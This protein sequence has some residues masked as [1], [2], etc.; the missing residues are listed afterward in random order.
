MNYKERKLK[1][2]L[3]EQTLK[4][5][6]EHAGKNN[7]EQATAL[8]DL[9]IIQKSFEAISMSVFVEDQKRYISLMR[10]NEAIW[11]TMLK[12]EEEGKVTQCRPVS[13]DN[14][15]NTPESFIESFCY[16]FMEIL[17]GKHND[18]LQSI[19]DKSRGL[20]SMENVKKGDFVQCLI[21]HQQSQTTLTNGVLYKI[22]ETRGDIFFI[23]DDENKKRRYKMSNAQFQ[24]IY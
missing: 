6:K 11:S 24:L 22:I 13:S 15:G 9:Q 2:L 1:G 3:A 19:I 5:F 21:V 8:L 18:F 20:T 16:S 14:Y 12:L 10:G 4:Y 23:Y 17:E 7:Q